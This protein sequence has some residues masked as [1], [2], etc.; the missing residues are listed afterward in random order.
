MPCFSLWLAS[1]CARGRTLLEDVDR[2]VVKRGDEG[3]AGVVVVH[4]AVHHQIAGRFA[5]VDV[6]PRSVDAA[7]HVQAALFFVDVRLIGGGLERPALL[8]GVA[9]AV[10]G[11]DLGAAA[12]GVDLHDVCNRLRVACIIVGDDDP[13]GD[14][15]RDGV[16]LHRCDVVAGAIDAAALAQLRALRLQ[17]ESRHRNQRHQHAKRHQRRSHFGSFPV[18]HVFSPFFV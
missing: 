17:T 8:A 16:V 2:A 3:A 1:A 13:L 10:A 5:G 7:H 14:V 9:V 6:E 11:H 18:L 15:G 4:H 12:G